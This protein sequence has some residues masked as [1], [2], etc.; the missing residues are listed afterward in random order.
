VKHSIK[1]DQTMPSP[2]FQINAAREHVQALKHQPETANR[3]QSAART[4]AARGREECVQA[5]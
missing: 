1:K 2:D 5:A 3:K 4:R